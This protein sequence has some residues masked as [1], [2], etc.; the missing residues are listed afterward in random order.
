MCSYALEKLAVS[1][2]RNLGWPRLERKVQSK[3]RLYACLPYRQ[4][5]AGTVLVWI[6]PNMDSSCRRDSG[7]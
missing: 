6:A 7:R 2:P 1:D 5:L 4:M 3:L